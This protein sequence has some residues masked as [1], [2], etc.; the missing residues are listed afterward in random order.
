[1][2]SHRAVH[3]AIL[4][5][6]AILAPGPDKRPIVKLALELDEELSERCENCALWGP[7][8]HEKGKEC[9]HLVM[10]TD[11]CGARFRSRSDYCSGF[12]RES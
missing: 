8:E 2:R 5:C 6:D 12:R 4:L 10:G 7:E 9:R 3:L 1:M 11:G